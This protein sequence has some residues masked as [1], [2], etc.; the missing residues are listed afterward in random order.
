M[1]GR[2]W[3]ALAASL[4]ALP[5]AAQ[6]EERITRFISEV[7][8]QPDSSLEVTETI[9][10]IA[11]G[12]QIR[13]GIFRDFPTRYK[14]RNGGQVRVGFTLGGVTRD[15]AAAPAA[16]EPRPPGAR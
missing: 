1:P 2:F 3:A 4:L 9:D 12:N 5:A 10:V 6:A 7:E 15:G 14:G 13:R 8:V 16:G 11:E